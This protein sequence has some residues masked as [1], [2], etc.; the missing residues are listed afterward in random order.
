LILDN[1]N[2]RHAKSPQQQRAGQSPSFSGIGYVVMPMPRERA[3]G[4]PVSG[5]SRSACRCFR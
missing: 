5:E 3:G 2:S 1:Q 4:S